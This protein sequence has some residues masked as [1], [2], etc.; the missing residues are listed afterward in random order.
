MEK[1]E[2]RSSQ[3]NV[4]K[5][6]FA[7]TIGAL[8]P[9]F[10]PPLGIAPLLAVRNMGGRKRFAFIGVVLLSVL[11]LMS[12][13]GF[14]GAWLPF[15]C[16]FVLSGI[17]SEMIVSGHSVISAGTVAVSI[18]TGTLAISLWGWLQVQ[19]VGF[20]TWS[21]KYVEQVS[22]Q[23]KLFAPEAT[24]EATELLKMAPSGLI[25]L[26]MVALWI[27]ILFES[28]F[29][30]WL[31]QKIVVRPAL[32]AFQV[33]DFAVWLVIGSVAGAYISHEIVWLEV[34]CQNV[35]NVL[36]VVY[37]FQ[38]LAVVANYFRVAQVGQLWQTLWYAL[39]IFH[40]FML[41]S[42]FGFADYWLDFR[43]RINKKKEVTSKL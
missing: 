18:T 23:M 27:G 28:R 16:L 29:R 36:A 15:L 40:M 14:E 21:Q 19:G 37:F 43:Q 39:L 31:G 1:A 26:M 42:V 12:M 25:I 5:G 2:S 17:Y 8:L 9:L 38:G 33:P 35:F 11:V 20:M 22:V 30:F 6:L 7:A 4:E 3:H 41:V 32:E 24:L 13:V 10:F 34:L